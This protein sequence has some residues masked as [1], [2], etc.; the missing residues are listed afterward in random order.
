[1]QEVK[2][3]GGQLTCG[4]DG[5][6]AGRRHLPGTV[7]VPHVGAVGRKVGQ[8]AVGRHHSQLPV[9]QE[10]NQDVTSSS[11][12]HHHDDDVTSS[13]VQ[14]KPGAQGVCVCV[15]ATCGRGS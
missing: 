11:H 3:R 6:V 14:G 2:G 1:M 13:R 7:G 5:G 10:D 12:R 4:V 8:E 15:C 9:R